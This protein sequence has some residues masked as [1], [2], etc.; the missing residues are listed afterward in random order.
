[1][2]ALFEVI[3]SQGGNWVGLDSFFNANK[4]PTSD[5]YDIFGDV[6]QSLDDNARGGDD[7]LIGL[8]DGF[9]NIIWGDARLMNGN[10]VGGNDLIRGGSGCWENK[11]YG[12]A[13]NMNEFARGGHDLIKAGDGTNFHTI[14]G[15]AATMSDNT[16]GGN[17]LILGGADTNYTSLYGDASILSG[18][19]RGGNDIIFAGSTTTT[20]GSS[21]IYGDAGELRDNARGG[22]DVLHS[23]TD[24]D[25]MWGDGRIVGEGA[26]GGCDTF[27]FYID[28][29][30]DTINDFEQGKDKIDFSNVL[31]DLPWDIP[32]DSLPQKIIDVLIDISLFDADFG[33]LDTNG[34]GI[35]DEN[36]ENVSYSASDEDTIIDLGSANG[37]EPGQNTV[38]VLGVIGLTEADFIF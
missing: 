1:M 27:V 28:N 20:F 4:S 34:N 9:L 10:S 36:D 5:S 29:G 14:Y 38:S 6:M 15:D 26:V 23:G 3:G 31:L 24:D 30:E 12:D 16:R 25:I 35:L 17:D 32:V 37:G 18:N 7:I 21:V 13:E 19:A 33:S 22:S 11:I 8:N 2:A